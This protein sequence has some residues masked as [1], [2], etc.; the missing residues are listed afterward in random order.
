MFIHKKVSLPSK[1]NTEL[2]YY[3]HK[4]EINKVETIQWRSDAIS[5]VKVVL[6]HQWK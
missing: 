2:K 5:L 3:R 1:K 4:Y 6:F